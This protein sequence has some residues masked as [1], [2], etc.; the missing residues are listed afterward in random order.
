MK[1]RLAL[2]LVTILALAAVVRSQSPTG[3]D[4]PPWFSDVFPPEE[5]ADAILMTE[6]GFEN[7]SEFVPVE[8]DAIEK[9]MREPGLRR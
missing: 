2:V 1:L 3:R 7:L 8:V 6:T 4:A 9:V 5:Y